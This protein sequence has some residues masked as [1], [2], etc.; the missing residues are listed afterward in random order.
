MVSRRSSAFI[1]SFLV[2]FQRCFCGLMNRELDSASL[3]AARTVQAP[4]AIS[5]DSLAAEHN[6]VIWVIRF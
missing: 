6:P 2:T 4:G 1:L 3:G 5:R